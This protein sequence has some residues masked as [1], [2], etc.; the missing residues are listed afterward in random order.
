[1]G[2]RLAGI[3]ADDLFQLHAYIYSTDDNAASCSFPRCAIL[4]LEVLRS[5]TRPVGALVAT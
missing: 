2:Q 5:R 4:S 3:S 1:M